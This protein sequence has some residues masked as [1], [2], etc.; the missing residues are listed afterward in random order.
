MSNNENKFDFQF[1]ADLAQKDP[2][3]FEKQRKQ[4]IDQYLSSIEDKA[5]QAR[6]SKLQWR[7]DMERKKSKNPMDT[8]VR[9]YDMMWASVSKNYDVL[10]ELSDMTSKNTVQPKKP[11]TKA[12]V[13]KFVKKTNPTDEKTSS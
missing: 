11:T 5:L 13:L 3:A 2:D 8:T 9:I 7:V 12:P 4:T 1:W 10:Q 6:L